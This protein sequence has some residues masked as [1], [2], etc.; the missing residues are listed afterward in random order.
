MGFIMAFSSMSLCFL[1]IL[2]PPRYLMPLLKVDL[3]MNFQV[4]FETKSLFT[5]Y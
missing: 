1:F 2:H 5:I 4:K 3:G